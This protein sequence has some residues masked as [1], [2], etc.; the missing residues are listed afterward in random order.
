MGSINSFRGIFAF[1]SSGLLCER[2]EQCKHC[3]QLTNSKLPKEIKKYRKVRPLD[4]YFLNYNGE[5]IELTLTFSKMK[6]F[7]PHKIILPAPSLSSRSPFLPAQ[8]PVPCLQTS[9]CGLCTAHA[10]NLAQ[11]NPA[12][13]GS[14]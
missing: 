1:I 10:Q 2:R 11:Y 9:R 8:E 6:P 12:I 3:D 7:A 5:F 13:S 14:E 4:L